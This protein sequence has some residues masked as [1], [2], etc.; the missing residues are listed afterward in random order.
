MARKPHFNLPGV[1][2]L[3]V[4]RAIH[5]EPCFFVDK[6]YQFYLE[7]LQAAANE[8]NCHVH[9]YVLMSNHVHL[10][11][12]PYA[13]S[14]VTQLMQA[15]SSRYASYIARTYGTTGSL[16]EGGFQSCP[17]DAED[18]LLACMRYIEMN[19]VRAEMV[20]QPE[21]YS[22]S[23]YHRNALNKPDSVIHP[24]PVYMELATSEVERSS[25]YH[26]LCQAPLEREMLSEIRDALDHEQVLGHDSF[27]EK[28]KDITERAKTEEVCVECVMYY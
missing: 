9:A 13:D 4:Q 19:P 17:V 25:S 14:G 12:T 8:F 10:L 24:H 15:L 11:I 20:D 6:D 22:W 1:P 18:Y 23:S 27:K 21:Q 2:Q 26:Q 7:N 3:I 5:R 28:I 16:W